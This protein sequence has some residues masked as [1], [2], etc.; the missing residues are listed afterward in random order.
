MGERDLIARLDRL[1]VADRGL[2]FG[3]EGLQRGLFVLKI[4]GL[5]LGALQRA[6]ES[7]QSSVDARLRTLD[8][9]RVGDVVAR[10]ELLEFLARP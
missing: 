5:R 1:Q 9:G 2:V 6:V 10:V 7:I 8:A 4:L 3:F